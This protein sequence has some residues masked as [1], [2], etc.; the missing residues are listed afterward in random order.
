MKKV[1]FSIFMQIGSIERK[2]RSIYVQ[3]FYQKKIFKWPI[4]PSIYLLSVSIN[5][6]IVWWW[7]IL[8][9]AG[10]PCSLTHWLWPSFGSWHNSPKTH[11]QY[12][13]ILHLHSPKILMVTYLIGNLKPLFSKLLFNILLVCQ[14][15]VN[16]RLPLKNRQ[17]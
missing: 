16:F 11:S 9:T 2:L 10:L 14:S 1:R 8:L 5:V 17:F 7:F 13:V 15:V 6:L 4:F 3:N 12:F